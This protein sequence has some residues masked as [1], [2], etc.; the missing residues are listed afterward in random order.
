MPRTT[1]PVD[2]TDMA[3]RLWND[4]VSFAEIAA[5]VRVS[6][7]II[8]R[9]AVAGKLLRLGLKRGRVDRP[10]KV[11]AAPLAVVV[12]RAS[13]TLP[14][15]STS[16]ELPP[17]SPETMVPIWLLGD[18]MCRWPIGDP[19]EDFE[20]F[21]Y[22]GAA[23]EGRESHCAFHRHIGEIPLQQRDTRRLMRALAP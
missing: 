1:W 22:C 10:H 9:S 6:G 18:N 19:V 13:R 21:R 8:T 3:V 5:A 17:P 15:M 12:A 2:A 20:G 14:A 16:P 4:G 11:T 23:V 7:H